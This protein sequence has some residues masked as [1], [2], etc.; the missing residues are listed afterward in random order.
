MIFP[1]RSQAGRRLAHSLQHYADDEGIVLALPRGGVPIG[2]EVAKALKFALD[3]L[4]VRKL[5]APFNP[6][7]GIGAIAPEGVR[8]LDDAVIQ[9]LR[10]HKDDIASIEKKERAELGRRVHVYRGNNSFPEVRDKTVIVVDDG[11]ATGVTARAAVKA[12]LEKKPRKLIIAFPVCSSDAIEGLQLLIRRRVDK[13]MCLTTPWELGA[14]GAWYDNFNPVSD[15]EVIRLL[16]QAK[17]IVR[18]ERDSNPR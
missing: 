14:V 11:A 12:V 15:E 3:V 17:K 7:F 9:S 5:G 2:L 13:V 10:L 16:K 1:D 8:I 6:E 4:V 18:R